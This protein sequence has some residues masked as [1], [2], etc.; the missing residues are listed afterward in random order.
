MANPEQ[1]TQQQV[2]VKRERQLQYERYFQYAKMGPVI[3]GLHQDLVPQGITYMAENDWL[4]MSFL[5]HKQPSKCPGDC[6]GGI[7]KLCKGRAF[8]KRR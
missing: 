3:P 7:R 4:I 5:S 6:R 2:T 1:I 8:A